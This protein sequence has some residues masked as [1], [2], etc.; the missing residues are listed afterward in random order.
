[1][2]TRV[3]DVSSEGEGGDGDGSGS[4]PA[5]YRDVEPGT[6]EVGELWCRGPTVFSGA[7]SPSLHA[8]LAACKRSPG[9]L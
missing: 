7:P 4:G 2:E 1:M 6:G 8:C 3:V 5:V 9:Y